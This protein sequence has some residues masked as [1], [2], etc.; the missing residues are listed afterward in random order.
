M[1]N[2]KRTWFGIVFAFTVL[3]VMLAVAKVAAP[4][5]TAADADTLPFFQG[6]ATLGL[7]AAVIWCVT[8]LRLRGEIG[9]PLELPAH[10][11]FQT[12]TLV[13]LALSE[14]G[15]VA[16]FA[17]PGSTWQGMLPF[18]AGTLVVNLLFVLPAGLAYY[19]ALDERG[20]NG[21]G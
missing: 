1:D 3:P 4:V 6:F 5:S 9:G 8:K 7:G 16:A 15:T 11:R 19:R 21:S 10:P 12:N 2:P 14:L 18:L 13:G 20:P 17:A